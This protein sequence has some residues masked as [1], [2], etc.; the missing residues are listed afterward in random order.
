M[1]ATTRKDVENVLQSLLKP[2]H[3]HFFSLDQLNNKYKLNKLRQ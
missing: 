3:N 1:V 2:D